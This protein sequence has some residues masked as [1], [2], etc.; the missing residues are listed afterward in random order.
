MRNTS[1]ELDSARAILSTYQQ[2]HDESTIHKRLVRSKLHQKNKQLLNELSL[3]KEKYSILK[4]ELMN[5]DERLNRLNN[6]LM[7]KTAHM[8]RLQEDYENAIYQLTKAEE[9]K[10]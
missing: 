6:Q 8:V 2:V 10:S 5:R 4:K 7:D 1:I 9:C 3:L